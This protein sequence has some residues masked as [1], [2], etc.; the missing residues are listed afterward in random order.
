MPTH[1]GLLAG[2]LQEPRPDGDHVVDQLIAERTRTISRHPLWPLLR[3]ILVRA[4]H[5]GEAVR[6]ADHITRMDGRSAFAHVSRLLAL[7][8]S[9]AGLD[10][11]PRDGGIILVPNH[12]TGIADGIAMF[13]VLA[14]IRPDLVFFGN[15]D[16]LRVAPGFRDLVIPVEWRADAKSYGKSRD[17][18][19]MTA[20]TFAERRAIVLF[21]SGRLAFLKDGRLTE[22]PWQVSAITLAR[23]YD[24]PI[25]PVHIDARNS[26]L[27]YLLSRVSAEMRDMT[28]FHELLN[29]KGKRFALTFG[30]PIAPERIA[31]EP[32]EAIA[33][34]HDFVT[35][36][37][38]GRPA[39]RFA[40]PGDAGRQAA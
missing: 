29:K 11:I 35:G 4:L 5:Y 24:V 36:A 12:P 15:R 9:A 22:R 1:P 30:A 6:M 23:R 13:D 20:R 39:A 18:L 34:L 25:V 40:A 27:F 14:G 26:R 28:L 33:A 19:E 16:A 10:N 32:P 3:P 7:D 2:R 37:L 21:P 8:I 31:G 38:P 17:T